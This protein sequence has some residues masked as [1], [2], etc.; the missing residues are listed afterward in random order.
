M[1]EKKEEEKRVGGG[2]PILKNDFWGEIFFISE[3][4]F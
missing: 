1:H 2:K 3:Y 4:F